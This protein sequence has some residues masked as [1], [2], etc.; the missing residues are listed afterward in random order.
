MA[1]KGEAN[2]DGNLGIL[3]MVIGLF[4]VIFNSI[5]FWVGWH[6]VPSTVAAIGIAFLAIGVWLTRKN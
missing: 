6:K 1:K 5:D 4:L 2:K 3:L